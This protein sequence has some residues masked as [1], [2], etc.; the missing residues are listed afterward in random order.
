MLV[1]RSG[2]VKF[3]SQ[4]FTDELLGVPVQRLILCDVIGWSVHYDSTEV[5]IARCQQHLL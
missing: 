3:A 5:V 1:Q 2:H 4:N